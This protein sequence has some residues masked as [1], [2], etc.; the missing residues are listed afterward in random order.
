MRA[1]LFA[2]HGPIK[3]GQIRTGA[4]FAIGIEKMIGADIIL[5]DRFLHQP[6]A[7]HLRVKLV[8]AARIGGDGGEVVNAGKL[9]WIY[10]SVQSA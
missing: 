1:A 2:L 4:C 8:I 6:H 7:Q 9:H 10:P 3:K 5:I